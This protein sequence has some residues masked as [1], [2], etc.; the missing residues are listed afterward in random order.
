VSVPKA[1]VNLYYCTILGEYQIRSAW[2]AAIVQSKAQALG[3][4]ETPHQYL[5]LCVLSSDARHH[6][7]SSGA[8]YNIGHASYALRS[9]NGNLS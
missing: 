7:A 6:S 2:E 1:A 4:Q 5:G 8:I 9:C 3:V